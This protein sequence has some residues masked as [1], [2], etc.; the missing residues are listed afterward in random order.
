MTLKSDIVINFDKAIKMATL[1]ISNWTADHKI[2]WNKVEGD[3]YMY[4]FSFYDKADIDSII[5]SDFDAY[6]NETL[7]WMLNCSIDTFKKFEYNTLLE[8]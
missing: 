1:D 6:V 8:N 3:I 7:D 4:F 5:E 2:D